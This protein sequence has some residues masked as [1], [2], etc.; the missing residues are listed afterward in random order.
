M[1]IVDPRLLSRLAALRWDFHREV[2]AVR[3]GTMCYALGQIERRV[4]SL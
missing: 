1:L 2:I 3:V 4:I